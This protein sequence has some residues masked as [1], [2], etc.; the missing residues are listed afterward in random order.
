MKISIADSLLF[1][2][3]HINRFYFS[4]SHLGKGAEGTASHQWVLILEGTS[5]DPYMLGIRLDL[6][7]RALS[8][9]SRL[10]FG[11]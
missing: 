8:I 11:F 4:D 7:G 3:I 5:I 2:L 10:D 6:N 1:S 9:F